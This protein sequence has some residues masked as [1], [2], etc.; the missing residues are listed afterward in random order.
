MGNQDNN[1]NIPF[2]EL[3]QK[4]AT[5]VCSK[6]GPINP[7]Q[8]TY[9]PSSGPLKARGDGS[10]VR[11]RLFQRYIRQFAQNMPP[12]CSA[13]TQNPFHRNVQPKMM[14]QKPT[15]KYDNHPLRK[16]FNGSDEE[17]AAIF[18]L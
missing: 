13:R 2:S 1:T 12:A 7:Q 4:F 3:M 17:F 15:G 10:A 9:Q 6:F 5:D 16:A 11:D 14:Q 8:I 18:G